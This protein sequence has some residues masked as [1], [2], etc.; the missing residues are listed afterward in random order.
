VNPVEQ[1]VPPRAAHN[2]IPGRPA[3]VRPGRRYR[4]RCSAAWPGTGVRG[5]RA[6]TRAIASTRPG[7][8]TVRGALPWT[9]ASGSR[10]RRAGGDAG[11]DRVCRLSRAGSARG[12]APGSD[13]PARSRWRGRGGRVPPPGPPAALRLSGPLRSLAVLRRRRRD[14]RP[15]RA[16]RLRGQCLVLLHRRQH[17]GGELLDR[18]HP[19]VLGL[20]LE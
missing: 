5:S 20:L 8:R 14:V 1:L 13:H 15:D 9:R 2:A 10:S 17:A 4:L 7:C 19:P 3:P 16:R 18:L 12:R 6:G 11:L